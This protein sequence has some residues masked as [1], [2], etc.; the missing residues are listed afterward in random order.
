MR[1]LPA[2][3][4]SLASGNSRIGFKQSGPVLRQ[5]VE[6]FERSKKGIRHV[7][8][9]VLESLLEGGQHEFIKRS[10]VT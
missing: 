9:I 6:G 10:R 2:T 3:A 4:P 1:L 8:A 7:G 5:P